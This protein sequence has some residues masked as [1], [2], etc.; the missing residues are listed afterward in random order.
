MRKHFVRIC[1]LPEAY[2][3]GQERYLGS[4]RYYP[5]PESQVMS[6]LDVSKPTRDTTNWVYHGAIVTV[7]I[8]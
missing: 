6:P 3:I 5:Q 1:I 4:H 8:V 7:A 2:Q